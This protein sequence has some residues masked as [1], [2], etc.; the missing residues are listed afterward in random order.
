M[1]PRTR[2][3]IA[4]KAGT[5]EIE[6]PIDSVE[7]AQAAKQ[8]IDDAASGRRSRE[9]GRTGAE[10]TH[11][12]EKRARQKRRIATWRHVAEQIRA[13][14]ASVNERD[15]AERIAARV[16]GS[17]AQAKANTIRKYL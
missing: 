10:R 5:F 6:L 12:P 3:V 16:R 9:G 15:L 14:D 13:A 7:D 4:P 1:S 17:S 2:L 8:F 11:T